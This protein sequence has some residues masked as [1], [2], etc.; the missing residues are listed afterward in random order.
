MSRHKTIADLA[1]EAQVSVSTIDRILNSRGPTKRATI[2]HVLAAAERIGFHAVGSIRSR[3]GD[4]VPERTFGVLLNSKDRRLYRQTAR[5]M[6]QEAAQLQSVRAR[7]IV[8]H[9]EDIDPDTTAQ[10]LLSLG[11]QCDA[12][13]CICV[14]HPRVGLAVAELA[15]AGVPVVEIIS[16]LSSADSG[17]F[18]G[19][20]D[21]QL[22]RT[23]GWFMR[24][25]CPPRGKV[26]LLIG[27]HQ[28]LC[29]QIH[30]ASFRNYLRAEAPSLEILPTLA[31]QESDPVAARTVTALMA[32]HGDDLVGVLVA[33][34]G[35]EGTIDTV[36]AGSP[37]KRPILVGTELT[38]HTR[39]QLAMGKV[40]VILSHPVY[41]IARQALK[42]LVALSGDDPAQ[43]TLAPIIIPFQVYTAENC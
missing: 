26:A 13:A 25:L 24:L 43:R 42:A 28:Y 31:T 9:L 17:T 8:R 22:G 23:A 32:E 33:G 11:K 19:S 15:R 34:G 39:A 38:D 5:L 1:R 18:V 20:N 12:I 3:L 2:E 36:Q 41:E 30:E 7:I 10:A 4:E 29:Q 27:A 6:E 21:W 37:A 40:D 16:G 14:D 35:L